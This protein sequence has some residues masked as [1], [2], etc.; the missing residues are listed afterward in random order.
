ML[1][2]GQPTKRVQDSEDYKYISN[3]WRRF[4]YSGDSKKDEIKKTEG[5]K[6]DRR[7]CGSTWIARY[8]K[9]T[10]KIFGKGL[11]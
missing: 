4:Q 6:E 3:K 7:D 11:A 1:Y 5:K 8:K 2:Y 9:M 10:Q